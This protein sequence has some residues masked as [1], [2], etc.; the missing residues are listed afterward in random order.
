MAACQECC[1]NLSLLRPP[2]AVQF[3]EERVRGEE[4]CSAEVGAHRMCHI[5]TSVLDL[6]CRHLPAAML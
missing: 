5:C 6:V 3:W 1:H 4:T 2:A